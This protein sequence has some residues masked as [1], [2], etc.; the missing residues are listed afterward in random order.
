MNESGYLELFVGPMWSGKTSELL[1][2]YKR[3]TFGDVAII[4]I[5][6]IRDIRYGENI[7]STHDRISF[8]CKS[9][10]KLSEFSDIIN[11]LPY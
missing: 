2:I 5:N 3:Y 8:P 11:L 6:Y 4:S 1:K 7:I 10:K 9:I